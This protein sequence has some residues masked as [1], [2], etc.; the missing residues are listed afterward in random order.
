MCLW[1][2]CMDEKACIDHDRC[3]L[4]RTPRPPAQHH[5]ALTAILFT[6]VALS[7]QPWQRIIV[8]PSKPPEE[9]GGPDSVSSHPPSHTVP[10]PSI[11]LP[12]LT[13]SALSSDYTYTCTYIYVYIKQ[14]WLSSCSCPPLTLAGC[15]H[16]HRTTPSR[17]RT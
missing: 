15:D 14:R 10:H 9:V 7:W 5:R 2:A 6:Y 17:R 13:L 11:R 3:W 16:D 4:W 12:C 1:G 8:A